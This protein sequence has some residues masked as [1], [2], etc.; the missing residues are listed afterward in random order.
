MPSDWTQPSFS[1]T[2]GDLGPALRDARLVEVVN[3]RAART[4]RLVLAPPLG[5]GTEEAV[6]DVQSATHLLSFAYLPPA[7]LLPTGEEAVALVGDWAR[8][9]LVAPFDPA[10]PPTP[11][12]V[13]IARLHATEGAMTLALEGYGEDADVLVWWE[14]RV[15]G[16]RIE[17]A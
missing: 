15:S 17:A 6:F 11:L 13:Q 1:E 3:D 4:I 16:A 12:V 5:A 2:P 10:V 8:E 7:G 14:V 9:G